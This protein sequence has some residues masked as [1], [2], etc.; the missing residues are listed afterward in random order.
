MRHPALL[1]V[2]MLTVICLIGCQTELPQASPRQIK[3]TSPTT[4]PLDIQSH[5]PLVTVTI[6]GKGP[7]H[8]ILDT[9]SPTVVLRPEIAD[10]LQLPKGTIKGTEFSRSIGGVDTVSFRRISSLKLGEAIFENLDAKLVDIP[11]DYLGSTLRID[12]LLGLRVFARLLLTID[13]PNSQLILTPDDYL[14]ADA[15]NV[16][17]ARLPD[18]EHLLIDLPVNHKVMTFTLDTGTSMGFFL[19]DDDANQLT[20]AQGPIVSGST[21]TPHGPVDIRVGRINQTVHLADQQIQRPIIYIRPAE[22][23]LISSPDQ[24]PLFAKATSLIG[25]EVLKHFAI[26]I[27]QRSRLIRFA[28][29]SQRPIKMRGYGK[30]VVKP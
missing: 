7:Y 9:G 8:L 13:Y 6:N 26:T 3:L 2:L 29:E 17:A 24:D 19:T 16:I 4:I 23:P 15:L 18:A 30:P 12:G 1:S 11:P 14:G 25:G 20:F 5:L 10:E 22:Y 28:R 27:D 21:Q